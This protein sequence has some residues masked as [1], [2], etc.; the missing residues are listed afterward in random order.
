MEQAVITLCVEQPLLVKACQLK[1]MVNIRCEDKVILILNEIYQIV[2]HGV[3]SFYIAVE[4]DMSAPPR[5][6]GFF[7]RERIESARIHIGN[8]V[9]F[10]KVRKMLEKAFAR[11]VKSIIPKT[12][13][14][15]A[16]IRN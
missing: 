1:L 7:I 8:A 13:E 10:G 9:L 4:I 2:I 5:P 14:H 16:G 15:W 6:E 11:M 3:R 12:K